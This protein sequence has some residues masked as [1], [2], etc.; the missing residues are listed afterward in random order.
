MSLLWSEKCAILLSKTTYLVLVVAAVSLG[1]SRVYD[2]SDVFPMLVW[3]AKDVVPETLDPMLMLPR[4]HSEAV[5]VE[6]DV[7]FDEFEGSESDLAVC[8]A[9]VH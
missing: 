3:L 6:F 4:G 2:G 5:D 1:G 9:R 8:P 7:E